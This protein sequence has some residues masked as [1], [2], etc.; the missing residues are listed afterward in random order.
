MILSLIPNYKNFI[1]KR[2]FSWGRALLAV[3]IVAVL[4]CLAAANTLRKNLN[5]VEDGVLWLKHPSGL[6]AEVVT[7]GSAAEQAGIEP[8]DILLTVNGQ[9]IESKEKLI[10]ILHVSQDNIE[11]EYVL[12][13]LDSQQLRKVS[14]QQ[15]PGGKPSL[16]PVLVSIGIFSLLI[17]TWVRLRHPGDKVTLHFFW[18]TVAFFGVFAFSFSGRLDLFDWIF[19]WVD[20]VSI[21]LLAPLFLHFSLI[22]PQQTP[23][24]RSLVFRR[25]LYALI[26]FPALLLGVAQVVLLTSSGLRVNL[27]NVI[28]F[29][30]SIELAYLGVCVVSGFAF[31][32]FV[33]QRVSSVTARRQLRWVLSGAVLGGLPFGLGY[34]LPWAFGFDPTGLYFTAIPLGLIPLTFAA[35]IVHYRLRDVEVIVKRSL[36]YLTVVIAMATLYL[37]IEN[38]LVEIFLETSDEHNSVIALLSTAVVVLLVKPIK[39]T[40]Q[41]ML[42]RVY[43]R[44]KYDYRHALVR[45]AKDLNSDLDL[46]RLTSRLLTRITQTLAVDKIIL[47]QKVH[48]SDLSKSLFQPVGWN[49]FESTPP[50]VLS[51]SEVGELLLG[52]DTLV[53]DT[54]VVSSRLPKNEVK[55][56]REQDI[57]Y[58]LPCIS[59]KETIAVI[60]LGRKDNG[61]PLSSEDMALLLAVASQVATAIENGRLYGQLQ[62]KA[63][64][65][66][67]MW[68]FS[69][70]VIE[71]LSDG[72]F[73]IDP[74]GIVLR[75]N[76]G[77][78]R[79]C[80]IP[81]QIAIGREMK[82]LFDA[83]FVDRLN[84]A[85]KEK[86]SGFSLYRIPLKTKKKD[87]N[88][89]QL[90][91]VVTSPL[92]MPDGSTNGMVVIVEDITERVQ[93][94]EQLQLSEKMASIGLL[95]AGVAH[96]IK[97]PLTGISSFTQMLLE[98][99][100]PKDPHTQVL[101]KID[102][103]AFR[104]AKIVNGLLNLSNPGRLDVWGPVN[105]SD[106]LNEILVLIEHQL[107]NNNVKVRR[108]LTN[109]P[110]I[111]QGIEFK[112]QQV[113]LNLLLN[114]C[115]AMP[116]GGW[117]TIRTRIKGETVVI[118]ISDTG[119]G[120]SSELLSRIYDPFFTTKS[121]G[122]GTG[123]G[124]SVTYGVVKEHH[125]SIECESDSGQGAHFRLTLP[126]VVVHEKTPNVVF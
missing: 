80:G 93:L 119:S 92:R 65:L 122:Q 44:D 72:L 115:D 86:P 22:F 79:L 27:A 9:P 38:L 106:L 98:Q 102:H 39:D 2:R 13:R 124:L 100:D 101:E 25:F 66:N 71:S 77:L 63:T 112:L 81:R 68:K 97:T 76:T 29:I 37:I 57:Y 116:K 111:I 60:A 56:W 24:L 28:E 113:F 70:N 35:A 52:R 109:D 43:Y 51:N 7:P 114:A 85:L 42:D 50:R 16:Y 46:N 107:E 31:M 59:K 74:D 104:A 34:A 19:Y 26:Y 23:S 32:I 4:L 84:K 14:L 49:G 62:A 103:Q 96:E 61:E 40:I 69:E 45:F 41:M 67:L 36:L 126:L 118:E 47:M 110:T 11:R 120:I 18:L 30:W 90:I 64:E 21:L 82:T 91:N 3:G 1:W 89:E 88:L 87:H 105:I 99:T 53:L 73:V 33:L 20:T 125:G 8:G 108:E 48:K 95:A 78:E 15:V 94:E 10:N 17:G 58:F 83:R 6:I 117:L 12:L 123:L 5:E 55:F 54:S 121:F 75:W